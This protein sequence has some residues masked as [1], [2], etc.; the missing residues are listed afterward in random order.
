M[1]RSN[2]DFLQQF[3]TKTLPP[4]E[5]THNGHLR[6]AWLYIRQYPL[7]T[8]IK[9]ITQGINDYANS[10]GAADKFHYTITEA[11]VRIM[12]QRIEQKPDDDFES[13]LSVNSDLIS[14]ALSVLYN[15]YSPD[16]LHSANAKIAFQQPDI[17]QFHDI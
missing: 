2:D 17:R 6:L 1:N 5:F 7:E 12:H 15:Y 8:A 10:L 4:D 9:K 14:D 3:E 13:F 16:Y 11:L